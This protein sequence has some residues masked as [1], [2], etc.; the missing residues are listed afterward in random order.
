MKR[1][2]SKKN[3]FGEFADVWKLYNSLGHI[4]RLSRKSQGNIKT[5][6]RINWKSNVL[7]R[8]ELSMT[9]LE[10]S[11]QSGPFYTSREE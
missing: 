6:A 7:R 9:I 3:K 4:K 8:K 10:I 11:L 5:S 2:I 1:E